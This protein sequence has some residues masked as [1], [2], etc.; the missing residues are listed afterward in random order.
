MSVPQ[1]LADRFFVTA[2]RSVVDLA[3]GDPVF[4]RI[5]RAAGA[6]R[7]W[8]ERCAALT[9]LWHPW[10]AECLDFGLMGEAH[11]FEAYRVTQECAHRLPSP[12]TMVRGVR[13]FLAECGVTIALDCPSLHGRRIVLPA[14]REPASPATGES[15]ALWPPGRRLLARAVLAAICERLRDEPRPGLSWF[16]V[17]AAPGQGG[18]T[19][20]RQAAR[21]ARLLGWVPVSARLLSSRS[22][23]SSVVFDA[24]RGRHVMV[25]ADARDNDPADTAA[26]YTGIVRLP[27]ATTRPCLAVRLVGVTSQ[28]DVRLDA[29]TRREREQAEIRP[30]RRSRGPVNLAIRPLSG[31]QTSRMDPVL[32]ARMVREARAG[33]GGAPDASARGAT[34]R[35]RPVLVHGAGRTPPEALVAAREALARGRHAQA[36]RVLRRAAGEAT[37]RADAATAGTLWLA[38]SRLLLDR[39]RPAAALVTTAEAA[40]WLSRASDGTGAV[41]SAVLLAR[42]AVLLLKAEQAEA[43]FRSA[44]ATAQAGG[45]PGAIRLA[46]QAA[47]DGFWWLGRFD[48]AAAALGSI[49]PAS[50]ALP[51][52]SAMDI[53][54]HGV[55]S[56]L[57]LAGG[58]SSTAAREVSAAEALARDGLPAAR[59]LAIVAR[60]RWLATTG[61]LPTLLEVVA[62]GLQA[63]SAARARMNAVELRLLRA[64]GALR[65]RAPD[66]A[67]AMARGL[68]H[69][70]TGP[71][72]PLVS[73]RARL[74]LLAL[75]SR[76]DAERFRES[77]VTRGFGA[78]ASADAA[79]LALP[80]PEPRPRSPMLQ[81]VIEMLRV[82]QDEEPRAALA[83]VAEILRVR[84][85]AA[86]V[87]LVTGGAAPLAL[88]VPPSG[89]APIAVRRALDGGLAI[90]LHDNDG[91]QEAAAPMRHGGTLV[92]A[93]GCRWVS[94]AAP[95]PGE[96][97]RLLEAA[98]AAA[99]PCARVLVESTAVS[100]RSPDLSELAG[101]SQAI[102]DVRRL[103][104]QAADAPF[105]VLIE[106]ESGSGK[107]LAA[108]AIHRASPRRLR[109]FCAVNG[110]ALPDDLLEA[111]LFGHTRGAFTGAVTERRGVFEE[112]DGGVLF[113]DEVG[114]L[115]MRAQAK[116][117]R[118]IQEGEIR[119]IGE[120]HVRRVDV[121]LVTATNR[122]LE[123][124]VVAG[125]FRRDL[126]Y[127]L[128]VIRIVMPPLRERA[129]DVPGL[130][131]EMWMRAAQRV[132]SHAVLSA[133]TLAALARYD[134]PGNVRE[135]Q[136]VLAALAVV[137]PRRGVIGP[138]L[139]PVAIAQGA[140]APA[141]VTLDEAR[142]H[143]EARFVRAALARAGGHRG[144][145][146]ADLGLTRQG[147]AKLLDRLGVTMPDEEPAVSAP[148]PRTG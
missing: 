124:E 62:R 86:T 64:E 95:E 20:L 3:T 51:G 74:V 81:D 2:D 99:A 65:S 59:L 121:R 73:A 92:G 57:A 72:P 130:A 46:S 133:V 113:L 78:F 39:G 85:S 38:A 125:R 14:P 105:N 37:R 8:T 103:V 35:P 108:R 97:A 129:D 1:L 104:G 71:T 28:A 53:E 146:A 66:L 7:E 148:S 82:C 123:T 17:A 27:F 134:W 127:R 96:I 147:L 69:L 106:G 110:A 131:A 138:S 89:R 25:L 111:E 33:F 13:A 122:H 23:L 55:A 140:G 144:R 4:M 30:G 43:G 84:S 115:S 109:P 93:L 112:A 10:L 49:E 6:S 107:E 45:E 22:P 26:E 79:G 75:D 77:L 143:F 100:P 114:E 50:G 102:L 34:A 63:A 61:D 18:R 118:A 91:G 56:R 88:A 142:R 40:E 128:A 41:E 11:A 52:H 76:A 15:R 60:A 141:G 42:A 70:A 145:A 126:Y 83:R 5:A 117:L 135:L 47:A 139:L 19:L 67:R 136:N 68:R 54:A 94:H 119:R 120:A 116:L 58:A 36:E 90:A 31:W 44:C 101:S 48:E 24:V 132:G 12:D 137:A 16:D 80:P 98:A 29:L 9:A 21:E 32:S 87:A